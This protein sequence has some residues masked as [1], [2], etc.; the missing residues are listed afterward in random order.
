MHFKKVI[1][2][3]N[4]LESYYSLVIKSDENRTYILG[5]VDFWI[6]FWIFNFLQFAID[7]ENNFKT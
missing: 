7:G 5:E 2:D 1:C 3:S 6:F 4:L